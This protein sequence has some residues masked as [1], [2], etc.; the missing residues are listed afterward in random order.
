MTYKSFIAS[1]MAAAIALTTFSAA[2]ARAG[3]DA[4]KIIAGVAALAII[5][6]AIADSKND[7][8]SPENLPKCMNGLICQV[9]ESMDSCLGT[10]AA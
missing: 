1:I 5:G 3:D 6:A 2:P 10:K 7:D 9:L 8:D 4:A